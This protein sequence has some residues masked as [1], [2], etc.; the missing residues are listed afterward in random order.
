MR[1]SNVIAIAPTA[2]ISNIMGS[3][4]C[5]E[6]TYKNM[7]VKSNLSGDF[8]VLNRFLVNDLEKG[9]ALEQGDVRSVEVFRW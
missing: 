4:P 1:N 8:M 6:P 3:S 9:G 2:T 7:F 5:I